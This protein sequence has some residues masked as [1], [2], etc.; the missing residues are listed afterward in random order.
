[1]SA[2]CLG[3]R[4]EIYAFKPS[5]NV[6]STAVDATVN[7]IAPSVLLYNDCFHGLLSEV[8]GVVLTVNNISSFSIP[9]P[10]T[11]SRWRNNL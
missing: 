8:L 4:Y 9:R 6:R 11:L 3:I 7:E 1:M 2:T 5:H 10:R